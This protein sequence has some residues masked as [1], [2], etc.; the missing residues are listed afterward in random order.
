MARKIFIGELSVTTTETTLGAAFDGF[1]TI[2]SLSID[3]TPMGHIEYTTDAAGD[4]AI[5]A[6]DG[7]TLDGSVITVG[8][9][10]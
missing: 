9:E 2:V 4:A 3:P 5:A 10:R 7:A 8:E 1:G 6:M